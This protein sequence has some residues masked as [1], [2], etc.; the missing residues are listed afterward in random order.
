MQNVV[1]RTFMY[2]QRAYGNKL[3]IAGRPAWMHPVSVKNRLPEDADEKIQ[4]I[5]LLHD[6]ASIGISA[7]NL[8]EA[9]YDD[10]T[11]AAVMLLTR[12]EGTTHAQALTKLIES[13]NIRALIVKK[14]DLD[15]DLSPDRIQRMPP[16]ARYV[17][18]RLEREREIVTHALS[19]IM[20]P[21]T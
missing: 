19:C 4:L 12:S 15:D 1:D 13:R 9:D 20:F 6:A 5:A 10:E 11:I 16:R 3:D 14:A 7:S 17:K 18:R 8:R 21:L 2:I